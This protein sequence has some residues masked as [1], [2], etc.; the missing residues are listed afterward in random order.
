MKPFLAPLHFLLLVFAG[1]V[2][3]EQEAVIAYL[4]E[5][6]AVLREQLGGRRLRLTDAQRRRLAVKG[7]ALGR[8]VL[9][10][11]AGTVTPDTILRWYREIVARKYDGSMRRGP[12]RQRSKEDIIELVLT[13]ARANLIA[14]ANTDALVGS[15][16]VRQRERLGGLLS[17][18]YCEAA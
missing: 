13:M 4:H 11:V 16:P 1:W 8:K 6:N 17:F 15:G 2:N 7:R 5:K 3:R 10:G 9:A 14:P 12:G 18:C